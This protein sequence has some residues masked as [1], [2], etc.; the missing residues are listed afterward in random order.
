MIL[1]TKSLILFSSFAYLASQPARVRIA[2]SSP[3]VEFYESH[4]RTVSIFI[5]ASEQQRQAYRYTA[6]SKCVTITANVRILQVLLVNMGQEVQNAKTRTTRNQGDRKST[7]HN[8][9]SQCQQTDNEWHTVR[10]YRDHDRRDS[11][12]T[13]AALHSSSTPCCYFCGETGHV[14]QNCRHGRK[15]QL[16][17]VS[18]V[19][20][21]IKVLPI[22]PTGTLRRRCPYFEFPRKFV[23]VEKLQRR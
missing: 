2:S 13:N 18:V 10:R 6:E 15:L 5:R 4:T 14:K 12:P 3:F 9:R 22:C 1:A 20:T 7:R 23:V 11:A 16:P 17:Y 8:E 21:Q 19:W